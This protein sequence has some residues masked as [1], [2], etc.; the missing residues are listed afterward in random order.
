M[1][2]A[3]A[4][5]VAPPDVLSVTVP[6]LRTKTR[7]VQTLAAFMK[8]LSPIGYGEVAFAS[9]TVTSMISTAYEPP[10]GKLVLASV[11]GR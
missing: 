5:D 9:A 3:G 1:E 6:V 4:G 7:L 2:P 11:M 10:P 8:Q